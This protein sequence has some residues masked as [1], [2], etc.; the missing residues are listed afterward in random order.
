MALKGQNT[1]LAELRAK[2]KFYSSLKGKLCRL[3]TDAQYRFELKKEV[4]KLCNPLG[5]IK[6][7]WSNCEIIDI[8]MLSIDHVN[9]DGSVDR[10]SGNKLYRYI[11]DKGNDDL[12]FQTLCHNHQW[13]KEIERRKEFRKQRIIELKNM[14]NIL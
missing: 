1:S 11:R 5:L 6:C 4:I 14:I 10:M 3:E 2:K 13:K 7:S 12:K 9:N 8:D